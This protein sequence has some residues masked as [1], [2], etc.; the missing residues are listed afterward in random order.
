MIELLHTPKDK[1]IKSSPIME[2]VFEYKDNLILKNIR[3]FIGFFNTEYIKYTKNVYHHKHRVDFVK[4]LKTLDQSKGIR[5]E[6]HWTK[7]LEYSENK[8]RGLT[9]TKSKTDKFTEHPTIEIGFRRFQWRCKIS[10]VVRELNKFIKVAGNRQKNI[11][12][13]GKDLKG[14]YHCLRL[15]Y[16]GEDL[17]TKGNLFIPFDKKRHDI[18]WDIK[19]NIME[20]N[21][22]VKIV[23]K[24]LLKIRRLEEK[25]LSNQDI[26]DNRIERIQESLKGRMKIEYLLGGSK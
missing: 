8:K 19:N 5:L 12:E 4:F 11:V 13:K 6:D 23:E 1:V 3:T 10:Y 16:E 18:L 20:E 15:L 9:I 2:E 26:L 22:A 7:I 14:L 24:Q 17:L 25:V 21:K